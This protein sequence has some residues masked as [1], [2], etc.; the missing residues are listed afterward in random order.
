MAHKYNVS[1]FQQ[2]ATSTHP[3]LR[4]YCSL[5]VLELALKDSEAVWPGHVGHDV[6]TLL[7]DVGETALS[8]Q[9]QG[10][11][12]AL[13]CTARSGAE[14]PVSASNYAHIRY[15]RH[16]SDFPGAATDVDVEATLSI[17]GDVMVALRGRNLV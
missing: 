6:P 12:A 15:L 11:L 16:E 17:I 14:A 10:R 8:V 9:L 2:G 3:L 13:K 7:A 5:V 1:A 4:L